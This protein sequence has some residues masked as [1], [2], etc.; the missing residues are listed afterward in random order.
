MLKILLS[1]LAGVAFI[2]A[3]SFSLMWV[4]WDPNEYSWMSEELQN[5]P[6]PE[7][8]D[9]TLK[10]LSLWAI[11]LVLQIV[12][13]ALWRWT[14]WRTVFRI[15]LIAVVAFNAYAVVRMAFYVLS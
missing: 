5:S 4:V 7:D 12:T 11:T 13:L 2:L 14:G 10:L 3:F 15:L 8:P 1:V 6:L 9:A